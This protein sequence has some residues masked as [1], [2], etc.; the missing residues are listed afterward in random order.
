[1]IFEAAFDEPETCTGFRYSAKAWQKQRDTGEHNKTA[2][3]IP[4]YERR[5]FQNALEKAAFKV[6][7]AIKEEFAAKSG[8][9][10]GAAL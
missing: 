6:Q 7:K 4:D 10:P 2:A 3:A 9:T 1:M 8:I 5:Q